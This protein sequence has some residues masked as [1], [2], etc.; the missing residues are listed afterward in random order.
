MKYLLVLLLVTSSFV[1]RADEAWDTTDKALAGVAL[2]ATV[3]DW[4]QS[5]YIARNPALFEENN[6]LLGL[7]PSV[8]NVNA[9]FATSIVAGAALAYVLPKDYRKYFLGG[10]AVLEISAVSRNKH[11]GIRLQF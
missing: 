5:R 3:I 11:I 7:H 6:P 9:Y 10:V 4:S 1:A 8:G 2:A